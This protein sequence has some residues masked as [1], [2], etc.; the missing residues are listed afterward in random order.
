MLRFYEAFLAAAGYVLKGELQVVEEVKETPETLKFETSSSSQD[1]WFEDGYSFVGN[2][3][4]G[5]SG[6]DTISFAGAGMVGGL[7]NDVVK[8]G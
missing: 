1:F 2:P 5:G 8:L 3:I 6:T 4:Y 7:F